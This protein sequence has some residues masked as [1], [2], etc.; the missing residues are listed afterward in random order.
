MKYLVKRWHT[1]VRIAENMNSRH[2]K[3][4]ETKTQSKLP[5]DFHV[6]Q[7]VSSQLF[8]NIPTSSQTVRN[9]NPFVVP[10]TRLEGRPSTSKDEI[11]PWSGSTP[12]SKE[13]AAQKIRIG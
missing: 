1:G 11:P 2:Y 13:Q 12:P 10:D 9:T 4:L 8:S 6:G 7:P 5:A 3:H